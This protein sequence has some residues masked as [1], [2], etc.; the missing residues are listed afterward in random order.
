MMKKKTGLMIGAA[1]LALGAC[2]ANNASV[3]QTYPNAVTLINTFQ[4]PAGKE[5]ETLAVWQRAKVFLQTQ[6]GYIDTALHQN[7][8]PNGTYHLVNIA[9]WRSVEDFQRATANMRQALPDN[10]VEGVVISPGLFTI[11]ERD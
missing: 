1:A 4:V 3:N 6:E 9:H 10:K 8:D 5:A 2:T 7:I 11:I